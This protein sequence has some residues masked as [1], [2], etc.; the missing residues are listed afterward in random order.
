M[1]H[2]FV[3]NPQ[4]PAINMLIVDEAQTLE[5]ERGYLLELLVLKLRSF[6]PRMQIVFLSE[7]T[8]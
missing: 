3:P 8:R 4:T 1:N 2:S 5:G 7:S 6:N